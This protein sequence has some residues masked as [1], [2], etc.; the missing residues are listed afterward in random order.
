MM[1][2]IDLLPASIA[3]ARRARRS[4]AGVLLVGMAI[5]GLLILYWLKLGA[6]I[7]SAKSE[8]ADV[9]VQNAQL[10]TEIDALAEF[11][12]LEAEVNAKRTALQTVMVGDINWPAIMTEL[13]MVVPGEVWLESMD[14]SAG[15][16]GTVRTETAPIRISPKT[17]IG[18]IAFTGR[19]LTMPGVAKWLIRLDTVKEF[20]AA[21]L[22]NATKG[23]GDDALGRTVS[24]SSTLELSGKAASL[25]F[26][27]G[28]EL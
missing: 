16:T 22:D 12:A 27:E 11:A 21:Y 6:D 17:P 5:L 26:L 15:I 10:Q 19:S 24:F 20:F 3:E 4:F 28:V 9:E 25:R 14:A 1:R 2:R 18:R 13:A 8:L 23:T 7:S